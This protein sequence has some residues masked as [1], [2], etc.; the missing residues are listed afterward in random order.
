MA[1]RL[2]ILAPVGRD[3]QVVSDILSGVGIDNVVAPDAPSL[4]ALLRR[5]EVGAVIVAEEAMDQDA[6]ALLEGWLRHQPPWSDLP[7]ILLTLR[8]EATLPRSHLAERLGNVTLL[9]RPLLPVTLVSSAR[10]ALRAR[11]R[12]HEAE[13]QVARLAVQGAQ[14]REERDRTRRYLEVAG[15]MLLVLDGRG[16]V[17]EINPKGVEIL[18]HR[19]A[20]DL[21]GKD[22]FEAAVP[23]HHRQAWRDTFQR[24]ISGEEL[25]IAYQENE[26]LRADGSTR[27]V[28]WRNAVLR[29]PDG[30]FAGLLSSGEDITERRAAAEALHDLNTTL[31]ARVEERTLALA[32]SETRFRGIFDSSFQIAA[33]LS[34]DGTVQEVNRTALAW[35]GLAA[36]DVVGRP[37]WLSPLAAHDAALAETL[38]ADVAR[39]AAGETVRREIEMRGA[40][41][42]RALLDFSLKPLTDEVGCVVSLVAEGRD[43]TELRTAL[44]QLHET[45]K[46]ETLGQLTGGVAHDFNNLLTPIIG[47]LDLLRTRHEVDARSVKL[48]GGALQSAE[49]A[50]LLV[51]RLLSFARRQHLEARPVDIGALVEGMRD[52]VQRSIGPHITV[53]VSVEPNLAPARAD[54]NQLELAVLNLAVNARDAMSG[55]GRLDLRAEV[56][57]APPRHGGLPPGSYVRLSVSDTGTGMDSATL[58]RAI[59]PFF[60][61]KGPGKGTGL[62]LS[63]VHGLAAQLGG[64]LRLRSAPGEGTTAELWLPVAA[65][66]A[67]AR[68]GGTDAPVPQPSRAAVLLVDDE[69]LVRAATAD[70]LREMGH[71]VTEASSVHAAL[72]LLRGDTK[73]DLLVSD[74]LM[75]QMRGSAL[76]A[77]ARRLRPDLPALLITGYSTL[78]EGE[79]QSL[80]RLAKPFR[81]GDLAREVARLLQGG[82]V[83]SLAGHR[84]AKA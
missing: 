43:V 27:V 34:T 54:P 25:D 38:R 56:V 42:S 57:E 72:D 1:A 20:E 11:A 37:I 39:A 14:L 55:G 19:S 78:G 63:M 28:A 16:R 22:W 71:T 33:L 36:T 67:E 2:G 30:R 13:R 68:R 48:I 69:E 6:L 50:A 3:S 44:A 74:Y 49:R 23:P 61:T 65:G 77:E 79:A 46:I 80:P 51:Q 53:S 62:G 66:E 84:A 40:G 81:H 5:R 31:E 58:A 9:E 8:R 35:G 70:M 24:L 75:P 59:E 64:A 82:A 32:T 15:V 26:V 29:E 41:E 73:L 76:I 18:G 47:A 7:V 45:A 60:T 21:L 17:A 10:A 4:V 83:V 52:L 12:Q